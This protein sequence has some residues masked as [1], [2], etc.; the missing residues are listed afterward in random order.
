[1]TRQRRY[2]IAKGLSMRARL[3]TCVVVCCW[4]CSLPAGAS[5][6]RANVTYI[7]T[8]TATAFVSYRDPSTI[9]TRTVRLPFKATFKFPL[10]AP[11]SINAVDDSMSPKAMIA[12]AIERPGKRTV[13]VSASGPE[14]DVRCE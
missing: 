8:G 3:L 11:V 4:L 12:C 6:S 14:G 5:S 2:G 7:V 9:V 13:R 1:M 10:G